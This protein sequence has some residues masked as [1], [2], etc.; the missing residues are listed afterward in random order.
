MKY[1]NHLK[2]SK[3]SVSHKNKLIASTFNSDLYEQYL[4]SL[5]DYEFTVGRIPAGYE[6]RADLISNLF[7]NTPTLDW[8][9]CVTN[10]VSDPFQQLNVGD[11]IKILKLI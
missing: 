6:H 9:I 5:N 8:L 4:E 2:Y 1:N 10:N 11:Q 3:G 7:Y